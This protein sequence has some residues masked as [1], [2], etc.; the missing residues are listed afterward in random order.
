MANKNTKPIPPQF[1]EQDVK[2]IAKQLYGLDG[3][4]VKSLDSYI[5]L[6]FLLQYETGRQLIFKIAN[7]VS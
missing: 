2:E 4:S 1:V 7:S 3:V 5:D 6:N